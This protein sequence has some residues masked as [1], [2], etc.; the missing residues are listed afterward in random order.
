LTFCERQHSINKWCRHVK[1]FDHRTA[2]SIGENRA[3]DKTDIVNYTVNSI[4]YPSVGMAELADAAD[5]KSV[6]QISIFPILLQKLGLSGSWPICL[7]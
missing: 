4:G 1:E 2:I 7:V 5:S 6:G 3:D